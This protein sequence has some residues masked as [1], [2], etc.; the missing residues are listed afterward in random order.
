M[1]TII[2]DGHSSL[3]WSKRLTLRN[4]VLKYEQPVQ[5]TSSHISNNITEACEFIWLLLKVY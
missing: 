3:L 5:A 1:S 4:I 2:R